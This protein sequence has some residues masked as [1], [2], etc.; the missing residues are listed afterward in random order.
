MTEAGG[1]LLVELDEDECWRL[2]E[3]LP[4]GR[5]AWMGGQGLTVIPVNHQISGGKVVLRTAAYST[6]AREI[7]D[8]PVAFEVDEFDPEQHTGASVLV[9]GHAHLDYGPRRAEGPEPWVGGARRL[10]VVITV[11]SITGRRLLQR[12]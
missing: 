6:T 8:S 5:L 7:D 9:R 11:E 12:S 10:Q 1:G 3:G 2:L 4:V